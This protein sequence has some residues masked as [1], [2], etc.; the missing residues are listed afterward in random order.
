MTSP[1]STRRRLRPTPSC[2]IFGLLVVEGLLW[3]SERYQWFWY[4]EKKGWTVLIGV[5]VVGVTMLVMLGWF[6][7]A[8]VF[9][10]RFQFS[11]RSLLVLT[12]AV[13]IPCSWLA[14]EMKKA[15]EQER[16]IAAITA[17][18]GGAIYDWR[19]F[20]PDFKLLPNVRPPGPVWR[21]PGPVW[22]RNLLGV[23]FFARVWNVDLNNTKL[24]DP[25]IAILKGLTDL[26]NL[27]FSGTEVTD[28]GLVHLKHLTKLEYLGFSGTKVTGPGVEHLAG[29][30][31]LRYLHFNNTGMTDVGLEHLKG[32]TTLHTLLTRDN[33]V[34]DVGLEHLRNLTQLRELDLHNTKVTDAGLEYLKGLSQL[35]NLELSDTSVTDAGLKHLSVLTQL[36][37]LYLGQ[38]KVTNAGVDKL[39]QALPG[40]FI[41][42]ANY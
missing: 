16:V 3:L 38:T 42:H 13:A 7:V 24:T 9:R 21:P 2:L 33:P 37:L 41:Q 22:L 31:H 34:T 35:E 11:I 17:L 25:G 40:C 8:L 14:V 6:I 12:A 29:L 26:Q 1:T 23:D 27:D 15:R 20:D 4:N 5:A 30:A 19:E 28:A 39:Q 32:L 36:K 10:W 18:Q